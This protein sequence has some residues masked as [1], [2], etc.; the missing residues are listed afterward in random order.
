LDVTLRLQLRDLLPQSVN[1]LLLGLH[2]P[3]ASKDVFRVPAKFSHPFAQ[4]IVLHIKST[5]GLRCRYAAIFDQTHSLKPKLT[6][7]CSS[8]HVK[9]P[10]P[11]NTYLGVHGTCSRPGAH[12]TQPNKSDFCLRTEFL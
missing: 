9:H 4:H 1:L 12:Y 2:V 11:L 3:L 5:G 10:V 7:E 8:L 6:A